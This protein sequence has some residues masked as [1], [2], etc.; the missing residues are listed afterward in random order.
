[1]KIFIVLSE[2]SLKVRKIAVYRFVIP[3]LVPDLS[4]FKHLENDPKIGRKN[5]RSWINQSKLIKPLTSCDGHVML[6]NI[7]C[8]S[9]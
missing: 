4:K 2:S 3:F 7:L 6:N 8:L 5:A 9:K 1:M